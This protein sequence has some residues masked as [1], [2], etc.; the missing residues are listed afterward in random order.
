MVALNTDT[1]FFYFERLF[2]TITELER[3]SGFHLADIEKSHLVMVPPI[4]RRTNCSM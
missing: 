4:R 3:K 1:Q 2:C